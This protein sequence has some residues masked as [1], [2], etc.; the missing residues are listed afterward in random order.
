MVVSTYDNK[1]ER[2]SISLRCGSDDLQ[3]Y[4]ESGSHDLTCSLSYSS[5]KQF[6]LTFASDYS[7]SA[8]FSAQYVLDLSTSSELIT[9]TITFPLK[10][11]QLGDAY[12]IGRAAI[13]QNDYL[14]V[15]VQVLVLRK[16]GV[17]DMIFR[18][19]VIFLLVLTAFFM[20]CEVDLDII[21][22]YL[23]RPTGPILGFLCQFIIMPAAAIALSKLTPINTAFGFGLFLSGCCP[24]GGASNAWTKLLGGD[25]NLSLT[26]TLF[27]SLAAL[28]MLPLLLLVFARF[29]TAVDAAAIPYGTIVINL[30]YL[31]FPVIAGLLV[32]HFR[33]N[34]ADKFKRCVRP[35]STVFLVFVIGFG[36][37]SNFSIYRLMGRY[38]LLIAVGAALPIIGY[39]AGLLA[40]LAC[41]RPWPVVVAISIET[42]VQNSGVAVLILIYAIPQPQGDLGAVMPIIMALAT[43]IYLLIWL[44]IRCIVVRRRRAKEVIEEDWLE[45]TD[46]EDTKSAWDDEGL[47]EGSLDTSNKNVVTF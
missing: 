10:I 28:G 45:S 9:K 7:I 24:G 41:R 27:S 47:A 2:L 37:I 26:M 29:Y 21:K 18:V 32:R 46:Q 5:A 33:P 4:E 6:S 17:L 8:E 20:T 30:L 40:A 11:D 23:K 36:S 22:S 44:I 39:L 34:W 25:L 3:F 1:E 38:P 35:A 13:S 19:G 15:G 43:P 31:F 12:I 14:A 42:G 16:T